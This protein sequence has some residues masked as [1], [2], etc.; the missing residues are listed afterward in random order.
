MPPNKQLSSLAKQ[1]KAG[2]GDM[3]SPQGH[4]APAAPVGP[5]QYTGLQDYS[6]QPCRKGQWHLSG[7]EASCLKTLPLLCRVE[8]GTTPHMA[9]RNPGLPNR[10]SHTRVQYLL[11]QTQ[12][13]KASC[14]GTWTCLLLPLSLPL[15][16]PWKADLDLQVAA[17]SPGHSLVSLKSI[18]AFI[19]VYF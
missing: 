11:P 7:V 9:S 8:Q 1:T 16:S 5:G 3:S 2:Y 13:D 15:V 6:Q 17:R 18:Y 14:L 4:K 10:A 12:L 19:L